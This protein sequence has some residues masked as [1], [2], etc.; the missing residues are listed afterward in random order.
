[1]PTVPAGAKEAAKNRLKRLL[2]MADQPKAAELPAVEPFPKPIESQSVSKPP[3]APAVVTTKRAK[4]GQTVSTPERM[5]FPGIY[6]RPD[7]V[8]KEAAE[9]VAPESPN[10]QRL[11]GVTRDDLY[12]I[13][14]GRE[15]NLPGTLPGLA[16]N[17]KGMRG[18]AEQI[19]N[20][21]NTQRLLDANAEAEKYPELVRGMDAWYVMDPL[22]QK[23]ERELGPE[24]AKRE[25]D[26]MNKFMGMASPG[27]EVTTEIPRG[28]AAYYLYKQGRFPE[29]ER[30][31]GVPAAQ[32]GLDFPQDLLTVPGHVYHSTAQAKP[33]RR[34]VE[35][36]ELDMSSPKV[37]MYI[38][39]SGV[40]EVGFQ[41]KTPVGD[42][43]WSRAVGLADIREAK[44][45]GKSVSNSEMY[46]LAPWWREKVAGELGIEPVS[47]QGRTWGV[48]S[49]QTGVT[50]PI[51]APKLELIADQVVE[52]A[53]RMGITPEQALQ[54]FIRGEA[55]LGKKEGGSVTKRYNEG[56]LA[57]VEQPQQPSQ[58]EM[59]AMQILDMA[60]E[61]GVSPE[62]VI[63][64]L[65]E[66]QS[67]PASGLSMAPNE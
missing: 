37:P 59:M 56:G 11:F 38:E 12:Q 50:T 26:M 7:E 44:N 8:A 61:M 48:F 40:P 36:G 54:L 10:L 41:T 32:R 27:S 45:F 66:Q 13:A 24:A 51:G 30:F 63:M 17:P 22:Y 16:A 58:D 3:E 64:M 6:K 62:E 4:P 52:A 23:M 65:M 67:A 46:S 20:R 39:A 47:A 28:T 2:G 42:A 5:A 18:G 55:R 19:T 21:R 53:Q 25:Y 29:F 34:F 35:S 1:M 31:A 15:G 9:R 49:P 43:H 14:R 60:R 57:A 33:M